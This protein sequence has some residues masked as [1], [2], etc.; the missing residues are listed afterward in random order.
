MVT[1]FA[2]SYGIAVSLLATPSLQPLR[3]GLFKG[4]VEGFV[5]LCKL[6]KKKIN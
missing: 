1:P 4:S 6:A 3:D 5:P 2:G